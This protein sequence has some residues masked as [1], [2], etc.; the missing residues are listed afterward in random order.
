MNNNKKVIFYNKTQFITRQ[1]I[2]CLVFKETDTFNEKK[3][4]LIKLYKKQARTLN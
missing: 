4:N 2:Y 3:K 1:M